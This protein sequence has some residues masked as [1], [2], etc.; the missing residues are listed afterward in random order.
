[1]FRLTFRLKPEFGPR[2]FGIRIK[3]QRQKLDHQPTQLNLTID[4]RVR[5]IQRRGFIV[6]GGGIRGKMQIERFLDRLLE[7]LQRDHTGLGDRGIQ[8]TI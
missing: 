8:Q 5:R 7:S 6:K 1:M 3:G 2:F 4:N